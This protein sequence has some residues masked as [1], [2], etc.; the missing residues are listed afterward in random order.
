VADAEAMLA[1]LADGPV[2]DKV[3]H[4]IGVAGHDWEL[5][6]F[7]GG[8]EGLVMAE[9]ELGEDDEQFAA[10]EWLGQEVSDDQRYYN[11]NLARNPY[12]AW[13]D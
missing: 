13:R 2:I 1:E 11:V 9:I 12:R 6:V 7:A 4:I 5:D 8:N 3:R 10:P